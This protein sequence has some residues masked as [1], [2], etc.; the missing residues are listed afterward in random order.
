MLNYKKSL[1]NALPRPL[2]VTILGILHLIGGA[3]STILAITGAAMLGG[4]AGMGMMG[5]F[6]AGIGVAFLMIFGILAV[7]EFA[8]AGAL[9]SGKPWGRIVVI[10]L[11]II[12]LIMGI[13]SVF[14]N[15]FSIFIIILDVVVLWYMWRP[16]VIAYFN[17]TYSGNSVPRGF[18]CKHCGLKSESLETLRYHIQEQHDDSKSTD[19][20]KYLDILKERY[21]KGEITKEEFEEKKKDLGA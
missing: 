10:I 2:G 14:G 3:I 17:G 21:A 18:Y 9:F 7:V 6:S 19:D 13:V 12:S 4:S 8:I 1:C 15:P 5:M 20:A 16:H 11:S